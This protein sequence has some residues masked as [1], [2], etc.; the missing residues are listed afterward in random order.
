LSSVGQRR[1]GKVMD[2]IA[3]MNKAGDPI[4]KI[5][6]GRKK[7]ESCWYQ[8]KRTPWDKV[9]VSDRIYFKNSGEKIIAVATTANVD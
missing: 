7:I 3:I 5:L 9:I 4:A 1:A 8:A 2:H 6:S